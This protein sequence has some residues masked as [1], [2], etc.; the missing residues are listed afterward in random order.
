MILKGFSF[1]IFC[2]KKLSLNKL[3]YFKPDKDSMPLAGLGMV[4]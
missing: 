3:S 1:P 4:D 2:N